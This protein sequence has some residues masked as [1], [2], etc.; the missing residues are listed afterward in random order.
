M[1]PICRECSQEAMP[2]SNYCMTHWFYKI[3]SNA[4]SQLRFPDSGMNAGSSVSTSDPAYDVRRLTNQQLAAYLHCMA[5]AQY[6]ECAWSGEGLIPGINMSLDH[7]Y[8]SSRFPG[9]S[10]D[11]RNLQWLCSNVNMIKGNLLPHELAE[12]ATA[13]MKRHPWSGSFWQHGIAMV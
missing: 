6:W 10:T 4:R 12:Y 1:F 11:V 3:A 8:P 9:V 5:D 7:I 13:I 2:H